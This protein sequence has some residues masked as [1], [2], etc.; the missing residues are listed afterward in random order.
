MAAPGSVKIGDL[1]GTWVINKSLSGDTD[2]VL[3]LQG[4]NWFTRV[5]ISFATVTQHL[6][7]YFDEKDPSITHIDFT[8][9]LTGGIKGTTELRTLDYQWRSHSDYLFGATP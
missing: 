3:A 4:V 2:S 8:Q 7:Q 9:T 6:K 5:A 1:T